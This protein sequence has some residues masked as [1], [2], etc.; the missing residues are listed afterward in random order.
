MLD[1]IREHAALVAFDEQRVVKAIRNKKNR[2]SIS[3]DALHR[4]QLRQY[5]ER[6][7]ELDRIILMLY[8]DW[9]NGVITESMFKEMIVT[10]EPERTERGEAIAGLRKKVELCE[11]SACDVSAWIR[12]I[13]KH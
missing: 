8:E 10:Y 6:L 9:V 7:A 11:Q 13:R 4:Q 1:E 3:L 2:E 5:E 12:A